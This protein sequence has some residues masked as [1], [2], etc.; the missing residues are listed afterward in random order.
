MDEDLHAELSGVLDYGRD[1]CGL[2]RTNVRLRARDE[3]GDLVE[4]DGSS[5]AAGRGVPPGLAE[6]PKRQV[7]GPAQQA[8][9]TPFSHF[10]NAWA[11]LQVSGLAATAGDRHASP[12]STTTTPTG[13]RPQRTRQ[14]RCGGRLSG[15]KARR[16]YAG[17]LAEMYLTIVAGYAPRLVLEPGFSASRPGRRAH[18][19]RRRSSV[20]GSESLCVTLLAWSWSCGAGAASTRC[21]LRPPRSGAPRTHRIPQGSP[22]GPGPRS[23]APVRA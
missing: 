11:P 23:T 5:V 21:P 3:V 10:G 6:I 16:M 4:L 1:L 13:R 20:G 15:K 18:R 14:E 9:G 17:S 2:D 7:N 8:P 19:H 12:I 22:A